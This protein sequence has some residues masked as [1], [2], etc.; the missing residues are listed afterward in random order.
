[1][2]AKVALIGVFLLSSAGV[3]AVDIQEGSG[4]HTALWLMSFVSGLMFA[5]LWRTS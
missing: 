2:R 5:H 3:V 4:W 1:M